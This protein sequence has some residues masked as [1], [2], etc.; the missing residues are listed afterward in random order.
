[1]F[2]WLMLSAQLLS[3]V[4][5]TTE[6][7]RNYKYPSRATYIYSLIPKKQEKPTSVLIVSFL[8]ARR[9]PLVNVKCPVTVKCELDYGE[10][11]K[12]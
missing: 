11:K 6:K 12:V 8:R 4:T 1:M 9:V 10:T 7:P 2:S 5:L 3:N